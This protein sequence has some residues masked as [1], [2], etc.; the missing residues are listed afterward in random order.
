MAGVW[1]QVGAYV[2]AMAAG[3]CVGLAGMAW[4]A[5]APPS[6][7]RLAP[8]EVLSGVATLVAVGVLPFLLPFL[9]SR[10]IV[11]SAGGSG[12]VA[13]AILW[14][15]PAVLVIL[16]AN[17]LFPRVLGLTA[18]SLVWVVIGGAIA[19]LVYWALGGMPAAVIAG[20]AA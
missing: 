5:P 20:D 12:A 9:L 1:T 19:G 8:P 18:M 17:L 13:S 16:L 14:I 11:T 10:W 4:I 7:V 3:S 6:G 15:V 2:G